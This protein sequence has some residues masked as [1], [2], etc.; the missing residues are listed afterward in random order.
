[1]TVSEA[2]RTLQHHSPVTQEDALRIARSDIAAIRFPLPER[3][4]LSIDADDNLYLVTWSWPA[5]G[6]PTPSSFILRVAV[7]PQSGTIVW[8]KVGV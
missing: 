6:D 2:A 4:T 7:D 5:G 3:Y 1:M 8:K